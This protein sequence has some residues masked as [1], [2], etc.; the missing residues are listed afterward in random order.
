MAHFLKT[1]NLQNPTLI[2]HSMGAKTAMSVALQWPD[3]VA[4]LIPVDNAPV[5]A[6]L[7]TD[8]A[9][10]VQGMQ[11]VAKA[12][13]V[14][15]LSEADEILK[16]CA[17]DLA[18]RQFLL[19]NLH[20]PDPKGPYTWRIPLSYLTPAL[21]AMGDFPFRDPDSARFEKPTL[22]IRGT[23]SHYVPDETLPIIGRFF[24]RFELRD[25]ESGHWVV[26]EN[27]EGFRRAVVEWLGDKDP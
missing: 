21:N 12:G 16:P 4:N 23:K 3:R 13:G 26:S 10:Y 24:P 18:V 6:A 19:Q 20:R 5:D 14:R 17:K 27:P 7:K 15:K 11:A 22:M 2:G 8:F 9:T 25:V 1:H